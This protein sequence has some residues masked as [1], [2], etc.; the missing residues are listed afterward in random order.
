MVFFAEN[1]S[2]VDAAC[3]SVEVIKGGRGFLY[4]TCFLIFSTVIAGAFLMVSA[5]VREA[6]SSGISLGT[7]TFAGNSSPP[8]VLNTTSMVQYSFGIKR[9]ISSCLM[10]I[11]RTAT[12]CTRPPER[13]RFTFFHK[14]GLMVYPTI[15]SITLLAFWEL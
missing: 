8:E 15:L 4:L 9:S 6:D 5:M 1:R 3:W 11:S 14:S 2:L 12:D 7:T 10:Q 13:P